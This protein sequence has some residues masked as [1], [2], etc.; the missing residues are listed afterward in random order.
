VDTVNVQQ[1]GID[2]LSGNFFIVP[3]SNF[4]CNGRITGF[5]ASL[6]QDR[7]NSC[8]NPVIIVWQPLNTE[9]TLYSIRDTY[10]LSSSN[11]NAN[12]SFTENNGMEFQSGDVIGYRYR[13]DPCYTVWN[14]GTPGYTSYSVG[15]TQENNTIN[16]NGSAI[17][18][19]DRQPLIQAT[20][21]MTDVAI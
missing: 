18:T 13:F 16:I 11:I 7:N 4:S 21:G 6:N 14:I 1:Q 2:R 3:R 19:T 15:L 10:E 5:M 9:Q 20:F 8:S 17:A 12:E